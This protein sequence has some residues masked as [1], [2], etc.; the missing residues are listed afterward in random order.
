VI[1][2][3]A[4]SIARTRCSRERLI[5]TERPSVAGVAAPQRLVLPPCGTIATPACGTGRTTAATAAVVAGRTT[6]SAAPR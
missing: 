1:V 4:G 6:Q 5:T 2:L 3:L